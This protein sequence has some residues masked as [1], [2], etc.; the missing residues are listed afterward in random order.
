M[1]PFLVAHLMRRT[2][3][4]TTL[5]DLRRRLRVVVGPLDPVRNLSRKKANR[6]ARQSQFCLAGILTIVAN[7][8]TTGSNNPTNQSHQTSHSS[9]WTT[10]LPSLPLVKRL[11]HLPRGSTIG[12]T[13]IVWLLVLLLLQAKRMA[14]EGKGAC[15]RKLKALSSG[16]E[17]PPPG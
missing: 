11:S 4:S 1:S 13:L 9:W 12:V 6:E 16:A 7:P 3:E 10:L 5:M 2:M 15:I 14:L 17:M 8:V